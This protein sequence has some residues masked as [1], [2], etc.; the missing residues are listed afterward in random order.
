ML[1]IKLNGLVTL[2]GP[3][4]APDY[5]G[6]GWGQEGNLYA[7]EKEYPG[8]DL[9]VEVFELVGSTRKPTPPGVPFPTQGGGSTPAGMRK[10]AETLTADDGYFSLCI[11]I[12]YDTYYNATYV[13]LLIRVLS[14]DSIGGK[15]GFSFKTISADTG[16]LFSLD[17]VGRVPIP[18]SCS[19]WSDCCFSHGILVEH[20]HVNNEQ[21]APTFLTTNLTVKMRYYMGNHGGKNVHVTWPAVNRYGTER[22]SRDP[23]LMTWT[24]KPQESFNQ[25][26]TAHEY[27]HY[28]QL[29]IKPGHN[30]T[31][32]ARLSEGFAD[33]F[34]AWMEKTGSFYDGSQY[35]TFQYAEGQA[36]QGIPPCF[37]GEGYMKTAPWFLDLVDPYGD[38]RPI[39]GRE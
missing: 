30:G 4:F 7:Q 16:Q 37:P 29:M 8:G 15:S 35:G 6:S 31:G 3:E 19:P 17:S 22:I 2:K 20:R 27:A 38:P 36:G 24:D 39:A 25:F 14:V 32:N 21:V 23:G 34:A 28:V 10:L 5:L 18:Q 11:P 33:F 13:P 9:W 12:P 1:S 26:L